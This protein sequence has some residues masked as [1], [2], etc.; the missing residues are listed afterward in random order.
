[1]EDTIKFRCIRS[2]LYNIGKPTYHMKD[3]SFCFDPCG[4]TDISVYIHYFS[5]DISSD[6]MRAGHITGWAP[7]KMW[8]HCSLKT[9]RYTSGQ[10]VIYG[11]Y[12]GE[13]STRLI[14]TIGEFTTYLVETNDPLWDYYYDKRSGWFC[15]GNPAEELG[16]EAV[17]FATDTVV[18][19]NNGVLKSIWIRPVFV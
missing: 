2:K 5:I 4:N 6:T 15:L 9:P 7:L 1:M 17:E 14:E 12:I 16:D 10:I 18:V 13:F 8:E 3:G 19:V 11:E